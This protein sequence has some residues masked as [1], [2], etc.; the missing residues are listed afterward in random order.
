[1]GDDLTIL[2]HIFSDSFPQEINKDKMKE[3]F[4]ILQSHER[5]DLAKEMRKLLSLKIC[6]RRVPNKSERGA[7]D[8]QSI[9]GV[10]PTELLKKIL[11]KLD[12]YSLAS[13][14]QTCKQ[15]TNIIDSFE[16]IEQA[17]GKI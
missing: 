8:L 13:A 14:K 15:W 17:S 4:E 12:Y 3:I 11:E 7:I 10:L 9:N 2:D 6:H 16:L 1:M 5:H